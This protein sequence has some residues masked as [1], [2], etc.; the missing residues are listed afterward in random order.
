ME[1]SSVKRPALD[2]RLGA[3]D[4]FKSEIEYQGPEVLEMDRVIGQSQGPL[5]D[6][7]AAAPATSTSR[8]K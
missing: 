3:F 8:A 2:N 7:L 6:G 1:I 5:E 4:T